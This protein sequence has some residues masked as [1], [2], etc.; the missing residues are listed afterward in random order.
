MIPNTFKQL[1]LVAGG[2]ALGTVARHL[3]SG[4][5]M[6]LTRSW[7]IPLGTVTVNLVGCLAAGLLAG[8]AERRD[9]FTSEARLLL[10][11]GIL[12]GF[13]TFSAFGLETF[14]LLRRG[15]VGLAGINVL[16]SVAAGLAAL[17]WGWKLTSPS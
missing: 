2:G 12:G 5:V 8:L 17:W 9:F 1:A 4:A 7:R 15:A 10:F 14:Y 13:T 16:V 3:I 6:G 11:T